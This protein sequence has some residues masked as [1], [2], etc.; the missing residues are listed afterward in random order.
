MY[1]FI[2]IQI[3]FIFPQ[4]KFN[5]RLYWI[6]II[7]IFHFI[8]LSFFHTVLLNLK[9]LKYDYLPYFLKEYPYSNNL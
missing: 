2:F 4:I 6:L 9:L 8:I 7:Y 3:S 5:L 1:L